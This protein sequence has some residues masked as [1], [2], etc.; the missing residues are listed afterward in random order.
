MKADDLREAY[1][2]FFESKGCV[3]RPSDVLVPR[4]DPSVLFTPAGMNQ[5]KDHFLGKC[6]LDFTRATSCQKCLRTGDIENVGRT[7]RHHTFFEMLGNFSFGDYFKK[8]AIKYSW[9]YSVETIGF[10]KNDIWISIYKDD[11]E[12]FKIWNTYIGIP[13]RKIVR[14]G[15]KDNFWGPAGDSGACG[16]CSELYIDRGSDFGCGSSDCKPGCDCE[17]FLEYWNLVFNQFFQ[18]TEGN[19]TPLPKTGID[20][21]MGLERLATLVQNVD[22]IYLTDEMKKLVDYVCKEA[23]VEYIK[24]NIAP[25]NVIV[26]HSRALT[27]AISD[28]AY[29][30]N[31]GRGYVLRRI[32]R[33]ALRYGRQIGMTK[34]FIYRLVDPLVETMG[35]YYPEIGKAAPNLK[36]VIEGEEQR[37][38]ETLENGIDRLE[39]IINSLK[40]GK[41]KEISGEDVFVLYDTFGFPF[42]MTVEIAGEQGFTVD[43]KGFE[44]KMS[45]QRERG[46]V[47]WKSGAFNTGLGSGFDGA[48]SKAGKTD[49]RGY[50]NLTIESKLVV[51]CNEENN[52]KKLSSGEKGVLVTKETTFYGESGG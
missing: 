18:D 43:T 36:K 27:F 52:V 20:T 46:K 44:D 6:K 10:D 8:E 28:G 47:S 26:E 37:F 17:R 22:S 41:D 4:W 15:K 3:R 2:A 25:V 39:E 9:D 30:S 31:E 13:E 19:L 23:E 32:L 50:E 35:E 40:K 1:L 14:L 29:P 34:P 24:E 45:Q 16:P 51:L 48:F 5:F 49:F 12:A 33:R 7:P 42:E 38:L 11:E 21:G